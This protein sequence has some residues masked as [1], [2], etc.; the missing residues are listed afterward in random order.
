[1]VRAC[2]PYIPFGGRFETGGELAEGAARPTA[3]RAAVR[4]AGRLELEGRQLLETAPALG[5]VFIEGAQARA[6]QVRGGVAREQDAARA[7]QQQG[8]VTGRVARRV[9]GV[10]AVEGESLAPAAA[11]RCPALG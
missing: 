2:V 1:M 4:E 9:Q 10:Q 5:C 11:G 8:Q 7:R 3:D 6:Q